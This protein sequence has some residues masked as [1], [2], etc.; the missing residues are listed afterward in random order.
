MKGTENIRANILNRKPGYK[1]K[2]KLK[3]LFIFRK[4]KNDLILNKRQ[5]AFTIR[6]DNDPFTDQIKAA[7]KDDIVAEQ[8][9]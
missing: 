3:D 9:P 4:N 8:I 5:L 7:Y 2:Q 6:V 1:E